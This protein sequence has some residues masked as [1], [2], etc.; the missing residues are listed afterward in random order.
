M[1]I[2]MQFN[3]QK[4]QVVD[5]N[6]RWCKHDMDVWI[7]SK[8]YCTNTHHTNSFSTEQIWIL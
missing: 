6:L 4:G 8:A 7:F 2:S 3:H 1:F 5:Q